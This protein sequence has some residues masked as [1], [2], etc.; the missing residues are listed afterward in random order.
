MIGHLDQSEQ[1]TAY[2]TILRAEI[3]HL[4]RSMAGSAVIVNEASL[5]FWC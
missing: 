4:K 2:Q 5:A 3:E 1:T